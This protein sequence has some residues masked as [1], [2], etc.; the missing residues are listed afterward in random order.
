MR[1]SSSLLKTVLGVYLDDLSYVPVG[2]A[3]PAYALTTMPCSVVGRTQSQ[4]CRHGRK[5]VD[6]IVPEH[7]SA[8]IGANIPRLLSVACPEPILYHNFVVGECKDLIF[9]TSLVDYAVARSPLE[10]DIPKAVRLCIED[11]NQRGLEAEGIYRVSII[12]HRPTFYGLNR[13]SIAGVRGTSGCA[14]GI[15]FRS[16]CVPYYSCVWL[17]AIQD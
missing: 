3:S 10:A 4:L 11:I 2:Y 12:F 16:Q 14:G 7:D 13:V 6:M 17:V 1:E 8:P 9:G 5:M 15:F